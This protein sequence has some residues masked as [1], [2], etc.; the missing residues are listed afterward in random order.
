MRQCKDKGH[1]SHPQEKPHLHPQGRG[2]G[3]QDGYITLGGGGGVPAKPGSYIYIPSISYLPSCRCH[4][5][6]PSESYSY[7][8]QKK[9]S[10]RVS[11]ILEQSSEMFCVGPDEVRQFPTA[12]TCGEEMR[13]DLSHR[14]Q[15]YSNEVE[16]Q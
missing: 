15:G 10:R 16:T 6:S 7:L 11:E 5:I 3:G 2:E 13:R 12:S 9:N 8:D 1:I 14:L 4:L